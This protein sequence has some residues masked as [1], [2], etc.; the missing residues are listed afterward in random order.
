VQADV[1][2]GL[3]E[4]LRFGTTLI[5]DITVGGASWAAVTS[6][7][8]RAVLYWEVVGLSRGRCDAS[9]EDWVLKAGPSWDDDAP[10]A[11]FP[12]T[13]LCRW[14]ISPHAPYSVNHDFARFQLLCGNAAI[15]LAES[16]AELELL[17]SRTGPFL[18]F[19]KDLGVWDP[20]EVTARLLDFLLIRLQQARPRLYIHCN[21]LPPNSPLDRNQTIV[22]CP[23]THAA[24]GHP[25]H[26]FRAFQARGVRV[27]LGTDSLA[28]NPDLDLLAEARVVRH[29]YP[30]V[31]GDVVLRMATLDGAEALGWAH[32]CGS[33]DAG[34]SA[35]FV[36]VPLPDR[37][38]TDP[39]DLLLGPGGSNGPRRTLFR[40]EWRS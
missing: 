34:K 7:A 1:R 12:A 32:E 23:R 5:G 21:Y 17:A 30:D 38:T 14:A 20:N 8:V 3:D 11:V 35:D 9:Y 19:L 4:S 13:A 27:A 10:A 2:E 37:E 15:H 16:P 6:A 33:L 18:P 39:H 25:P 36:A 40:G 24:F 31:P 28:S 22:Y 29:R 26:P